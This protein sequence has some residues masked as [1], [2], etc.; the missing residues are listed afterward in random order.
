MSPVSKAL[1][2]RR[3]GLFFGCQQP[4]VGLGTLTGDSDIQ[5]PAHSDTQSF[6]EVGRP[7]LFLEPSVLFRLLS[8][9]CHWDSG[10]GL[11]VCLS[12]WVGSLAMLMATQTWPAWAEGDH[13]PIP[14]PEMQPPPDL[15][16]QWDS[17]DRRRGLCNPV[18]GCTKH[19]GPHHLYP[20]HIFHQVWWGFGF[21]GGIMIG[22]PEPEV[23]RG[24]GS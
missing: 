16:W 3:P 10:G 2:S 8:A 15:H 21:W 7:H 9:V 20:V 22:N 11:C 23:R 13:A 14:R 17:P 6:R 5:A 19:R 12:I 4:S 18:V 24:C 1:R